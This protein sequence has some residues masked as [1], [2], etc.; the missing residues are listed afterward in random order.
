MLL[1]RCRV[2]PCS[3]KK[4]AL[5]YKNIADTT[6]ARLDAVLK[7]QR[8]MVKRMGELERQVGACACVWVGGWAGGMS[9]YHGPHRWCSG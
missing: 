7:E 8:G 2:V 1:L 4:R 6:K 3:E 9:A 5:D